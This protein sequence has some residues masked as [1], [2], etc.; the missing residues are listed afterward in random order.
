MV[1]KQ[2]QSQI[3]NPARV[4]LVDSNHKQWPKVLQ[5]LERNGQRKSLRID[6][7]GWLSARQNVLVAFID[8]KVAGHLAFS[9]QLVRDAHAHRPAVEGRVD[10]FAVH[11]SHRKSNVKQLLVQRAEKLARDLHLQRLRGSNSVSSWKSDLRET[12]RGRWKLFAY[13]VVLMFAHRLERAL[14]VVPRLADAWR[15]VL[16]DRA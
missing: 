3:S 16:A 8:E 7:D 14:D 15:T 4:E 1:I 9:V 10:G 2:K 13:L 6:D 5:V 12:M 11:P